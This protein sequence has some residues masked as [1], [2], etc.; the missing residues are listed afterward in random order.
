MGTI[1]DQSKTWEQIR[2]YLGI[3]KDFYFPRKGID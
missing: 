2:N 1:L 3:T